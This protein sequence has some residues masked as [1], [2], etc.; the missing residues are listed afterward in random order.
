MCTVDIG[1]FSVVVCYPL[2]LVVYPIGLVEGYS[3]LLILEDYF[4]PDGC[5]DYVL[6]LYFYGC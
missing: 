1:Y 3:I 2:G 4:G 5:F 6:V